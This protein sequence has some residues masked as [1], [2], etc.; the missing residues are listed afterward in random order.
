MDIQLK[1]AKTTTIKKITKRMIGFK[2][3]IVINPVTFIMDTY[4]YKE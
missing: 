4:G 1:M 2:T 3:I